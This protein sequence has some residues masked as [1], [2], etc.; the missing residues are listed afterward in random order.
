MTSQIPALC[1]RLECRLH[2]VGIAG[3]GMSA[4][5]D[6]RLLRGGQVSGSDR[7]FDQGRL[8]DE[9]RRLES[10]GAKIVPQ[11]GLGIDQADL[12]IASTAVEAQIPDLLRARE[13]AIPVVHRADLLAA[14]ISQRTTLAIAGSSGKSTV[15]GMT[16]AALRAAQ[17]DPGVITGGDLKE[18]K[19]ATHRGNGWYGS[20]P[21]VVE[22]D[23]SDKSLVKYRPTIG[24]VLNLH[25]DHDEPENILP[26]FEEFR[27]NSQTAFVVGEDANLESLR[28]QALVFGLGPE[29]EFRARQ[30]TGTKTGS[31]FEVEGVVVEVP[32][33]GHHNLLN[34]LAAMAI[35]KAACIPLAKAARGIAAYRGVAR[36]YEILGRRG[37]IEIVDDYAHNPAKVA[38]ALATARDR[39]QRLHAVFQPHGFGPTKFMRKEYVAN[40]KATLRPG[41]R[42]HFLEIFYAGGT[43]TQD[44]S[45]VELVEDLQRLGVDARFAADRRELQ[46]LIVSEAQAGDCV[47]VMGARDP[48]LQEVARG[49]FDSMA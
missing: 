2:F 9:R 26:V 46:D 11:D 20:G 12:V 45:S 14:H 1:D 10:L 40:I 13:L 37:A 17:Q 18:L 8:A 25:K 49:V 27:R 21:L 48:G 30:V 5:A 44:L 19:S 4:L 38:A 29:A 41:D 47:L 24:L 16:F 35:S 34:A 36:R 3:S 7:F 28:D 23:E 43:V 39:C 15:V 33:P 31:Q 42:I 32:L 22:A 6:Y